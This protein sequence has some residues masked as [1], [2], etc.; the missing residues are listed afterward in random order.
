MD[1]PISY[2]LRPIGYKL[3]GR[4][5]IEM[6]PK[7]IKTKNGTTDGNFLYPPHN[8][9][10][11]VKIVK[12]DLKQCILP[13]DNKNILSLLVLSFLVKIYNLVYV[14]FGANPQ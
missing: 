5:S 14:G 1:C 11:E 2:K 3:R 13:K 10:K 12:T 4:H 9:G 8:H 7:H 6:V